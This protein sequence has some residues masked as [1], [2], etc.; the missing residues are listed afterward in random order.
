MRTEHSIHQV[1]PVAVVQF[2]CVLF[3]GVNKVDAIRNRHAGIFA[4]LRDGIG[5]LQAGIALTLPVRLFQSGQAG[6]ACLQVSVRRYRRYRPPSGQ[7]RKSQHAA[8][9]SGQQ[10]R[11]DGKILIP[12][13]CRWVFRC[14]WQVSCSF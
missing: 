1:V 3:E 4:A 6:S 11:P 8:E 5:F 14:R 2:H 13:P 9:V 12:R 10:K 7:L